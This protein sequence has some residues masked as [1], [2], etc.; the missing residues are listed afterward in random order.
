MDERQRADRYTEKM[1]Y[2]QERVEEGA[3]AHV[4]DE[5]AEA[6]DAPGFAEVAEDVV[7]GVEVVG[8]LGGDDEVEGGVAKG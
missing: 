2:L 4:G 8:H 5:E 1:H 7:V 6:G 3:A